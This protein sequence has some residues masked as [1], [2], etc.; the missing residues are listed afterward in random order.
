MTEDRDAKT[1]KP[2]SPPVRDSKSQFLLAHSYFSRSKP[3]TK[4]NNTFNTVGGNTGD[5]FLSRIASIPD[6]V[7]T[8]DKDAITVEHLSAMHEFFLSK[9]NKTLTKD[10][11][12][13][14]MINSGSKMSREHLGWWFHRVDANNNGGIDWDEFATFLVNGTVDPDGRVVV[15]TDV[16]STDSAQYFRNKI[17]PPDSTHP[18]SHPHS[19]CNHNDLVTCI[20]IHPKNG[21]YYTGGL[22]GTVRVWDAETMELEL[23]LHSTR[24]KITSIVLSQDLQQMAVL[25]IDRGIV[26]YDLGQLS[27]RKPKCFAGRKAGGIEVI[28]PLTNYHCLTQDD[29][30]KHHEAIHGRAAQAATKEASLSSPTQ[31]SNNTKKTEKFEMTFEEYQRVKERHQLL[32]DPEGN[33]LTSKGLPQVRLD[34]MEFPAL[35]GISVPFFPDHV[36]V[37]LSNGRLQSYPVFSRVSRATSLK[38]TLDVLPNGP[39]ACISALVYA[40]FFRGV[41]AS[42][43]DGIV[44]LTSLANGKFVTVAT[45][46]HPIFKLCWIDSSR[47]LAT[48]GQSREISLWSL[49]NASFSTVLTGHLSAVTDICVQPGDKFLITM[50]EDKVVKVWDLYSFMAITTFTDRHSYGLA[51]KLSSLAFDPA[52]NRIVT[53]A[54][55]P[56]IWSRV[57]DAMPFT[58]DGYLGHQRSILSLLFNPLFLQIITVDAEEIRMWEIMNGC[59]RHVLNLPQIRASSYSTQVK[60]TAIA[61]ETIIGA[62]LENRHVHLAIGT[63]FGAVLTVSCASGAYIHEYHRQNL[64]SVPIGADMLSLQAIQQGSHRFYGV[65]SQSTL[66]LWKEHEQ[67]PPTGVDRVVPLSISQSAFDL[68]C[69]FQQSELSG[70]SKAKWRTPIATCFTV[71][72]QSIVAG[73]DCGIAIFFGSTNEAVSFVGTYHPNVTVNALLYNPKHETIAVVR[74]DGLVQLASIKRRNRLIL[75]DHGERS[76]IPALTSCDANGTHFVVGD[77]TGRV[78]LWSIAE[79]DWSLVEQYQTVRVMRQTAT[80]LSP[81]SPSTQNTYGVQFL[82]TFVAHFQ[83]DISAVALLEYEKKL[84]VATAASDCQSRVFA[85]SGLF[86]GYCGAV[87]GW[88]FHQELPRM[89]LKSIP[90]PLPEGMIVSQSILE[91]FL[92]PLGKAP[93]APKRLVLEEGQKKNTGSERKGSDFIARQESDVVGGANGSG[94][95]PASPP[96]AKGGAKLRLAGQNSRS[97]KFDYVV[98]EPLSLS[99]LTQQPSLADL[100]AAPSLTSCT[101]KSS[102]KKLAKRIG[103]VKEQMKVDEVESERVQGLESLPSVRNLLNSMRKDEEG[104]EGSQK[105]ASVRQAIASNAPRENEIADQTLQQMLKRKQEQEGQLQEQQLSP[106]Q[107]TLPRLDL[108]ALRRKLELASPSSE[109]SRVMSPD[110]AREKRSLGKED[111]KGN[112]SPNSVRLENWFHQR[113]VSQ[114]AARSML[115]DGASS[116]GAQ[117]HRAGATTSTIMSRVWVEHLPPLDTLRAPPKGA[118]TARAA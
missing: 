80:P 85:L 50:D 99:D 62:A 112:A 94:S 63:S 61:K 47:Q 90:A 101:L 6:I 3:Q 103:L 115:S 52:R 42:S 93:A 11:F 68:I 48:I 18:S 37:G 87:G 21:R 55:C 71:V 106:A 54:W 23:V 2:S 33:T 39:V 53:A 16:H 10:E 27:F 114:M 82:T 14:A 117:T 30:A 116:G 41:F 79:L 107:N 65:V 109:S 110:A 35:C 95:F 25:G 20:L 1:P 78:Y 73:T 64:G 84:V 13:G 40:P 44:S 24:K 96:A 92:P 89:M 76:D 59:L 70:Y 28:E 69:E 9:K 29:I 4:K 91:S 7:P 60:Y 74:S 100:V 32:V 58:K 46:P 34:G 81:R 72:N 5:T 36:V 22:D 113:R 19:G 86:I 49:V 75:L 102:T 26:V 17:T 56:I 38:P 98:V 88:R 77:D 45:S 15:A 66:Y 108:V 57:A 118:L 12:V 43:V 31:Q 105:V 51:N 104:E 83:S 97:R 8:F 111:A 67:G